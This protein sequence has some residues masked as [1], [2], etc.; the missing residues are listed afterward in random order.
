M[1]T[2]QIEEL[3]ITI[4]QA[5]RMVDM[6]RAV[7]NLLK[8]AD[9]KKVILDGYF[10][11]EA[12]RLVLFKADPAMH[13]EQNQTYINKSIDAIGYFN[14]YLDAKLQMGTQ[15]ERDIMGAEEAKEEILAEDLVN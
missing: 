2:E 6:K 3:E 4:E 13:P 1:S 12:A 9:F 10:K 11:E 7:Q 15:A 14:Q 8:N 5:T